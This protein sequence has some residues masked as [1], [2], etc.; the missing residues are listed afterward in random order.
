ML[1]GLKYMHDMGL[2]HCDPRPNNFLV[3]RP[4]NFL[5]DEHGIFLNTPQATNQRAQQHQ[6]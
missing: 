1:A 3:A 2:L 4:N 5:V 6:H